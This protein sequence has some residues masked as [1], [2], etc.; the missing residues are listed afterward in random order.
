MQ[1]KTESKKLYYGIAYG[2]FFERESDRVFNIGSAEA[3]R[4]IPFL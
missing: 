1:Q 4:E 3:Q 2:Q